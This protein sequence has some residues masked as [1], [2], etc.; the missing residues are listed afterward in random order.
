LEEL[1]SIISQEY[2]IKD[3]TIHFW[4]EDFQEYVVLTKMSYLSSKSKI[5]IIQNTL[6]SPSP[7]NFRQNRQSSSPI[8]RSKPGDN[9]L[10]TIPSAPT[11]WETI[12]NCLSHWTDMERTDSKLIIEDA[13]DKYL[14]FKQKNEHSPDECSAF[15]LIW[16]YT[17]DSWIYNRVNQQLREDL[18]SIKI[19]APYINGLMSV[20]NMVKNKSMFYS[21][22]VYRRCRLSNQTLNCY[23]P[24]QTFVWASFISTTTEI[25]ECDTFGRI[26]FVITIPEKFKNCAINVQSLSAYPDENEILLLPNSGYRVKFKEEN[27]TFPNTDFV[28]NLVME[29][30]CVF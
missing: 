1:K 21:G 5:K 6:T 23:E 7:T 12:I 2:K 9:F 26:L 19:L 27:C 13:Q 15:T 22:T 17:L 11:D 3:F 24:D 8:L 28:V 16:L 29:W 25:Q 18:P 30:S 10:K 14:Q 20:Y 4:E